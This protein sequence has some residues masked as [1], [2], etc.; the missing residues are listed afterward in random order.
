LQNLK[1]PTKIK[2]KIDK[3]DYTNIDEYLQLVI[4][5]GERMF[6]LIEEVL[7]YSKVET[8]DFNSKKVDLNKLIN[9]ITADFNI[10]IQSR[11]INIKI[12][13]MGEFYGDEV[14]IRKSFLNLIS[15][16]IK[17]NNK[18]EPL[19]QIKNLSTETNYIYSVID[20]G[21]GIKEDYFD[22][23]FLLFKRL[24]SKDDYDGTGLGLSICKKA[25]EKH[26][27]SIKVKSEINK[28]TTFTI[29]IPK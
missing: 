24:H 23:I 3:K 27:G 29:S 2:N 7:E 5:S 20:N 11:N 10:S 19:I 22:T 26:G 12:D 6:N 21:I 25:I 9:E 4:T 28:G 18:K 13:D 16:A 14:L 1:T 17:F 15:N 8:K